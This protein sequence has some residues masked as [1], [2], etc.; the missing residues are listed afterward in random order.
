M[1]KH[2][3]RD[4][5]PGYSLL[6]ENTFVAAGSTR[7][8]VRASVV[9]IASTGLFLSMGLPAQATAGVA[10]TPSAGDRAVSVSDSV[11]AAAVLPNSIE[12]AAEARLAE[13][14]RIAAQQ[15]GPVV[16]VPVTPVVLPEFGSLD[17]F[18]VKPPVVK[19]TTPSK[20]KR[21]ARQSDA[22]ATSSTSSTPTP[23]T[24]STPKAKAAAKPKPKPAP[25]PAS[26]GS[27]I[28]IAASLTGIPYRYGGT[29]TS[30]VDCSGYT[31]MVYKRAGISIPRTAEA[32]RRAA[33]KV[34]NPQPGDLIFFGYPAY[35]TGIYAGGGMM[36]DAGRTGSVTS[37]RKIWTSSGVSYGRF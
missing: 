10:A 12:A 7:T 14:R 4:R 3:G 17:G 9:A 8:M 28:S 33:K 34:S 35:H 21:T 16:S 27:I 15:T 26:N 19:K 29:S 2:V 25:K 18:K 32:Q 5:A 31:Q 24:A 13:M 22:S 11:V 20:P 23:T 36:Y 30:G 37:Y 6:G 1:S